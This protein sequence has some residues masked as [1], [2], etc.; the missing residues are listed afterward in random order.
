VFRNFVAVL[1]WLSLFHRLLPPWWG[2]PTGVLAGQLE[3]EWGLGE[4]GPL[5]RDNILSGHYYGHEKEIVMNYIAVKDLKA[6]RMVRERLRE[7]GELLLMN[8][9]KPM[10]LL[11]D[12]G[13]QDDPQTMLDAVRDARSRMALSRVREAARRSGA[14]G[15][16]A[17]QIEREINQ[18]RAERRKAR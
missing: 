2:Y 13:Q 15:L 8:N 7:E 5:A 16:S 6:P 3:S 9:G 17:N 1:L 11:L 12:V 14:A 18:A 4:A 10:A